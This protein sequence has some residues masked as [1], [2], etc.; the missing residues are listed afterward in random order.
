MRKIVAKFRNRE[1]FTFEKLVIQLII[2]SVT[3]SFFDSGVMRN[4][5]VV[6]ADKT[7]SSSDDDKRDETNEIP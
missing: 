4:I 2:S 5:S 6:I 7:I 1:L 3:M